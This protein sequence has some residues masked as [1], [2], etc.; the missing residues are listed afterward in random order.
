MADFN[1]STGWTDRC[2]LSVPCENYETFQSELERIRQLKH[3][4]WLQNR[5]TLLC[6]KDASETEEKKHSPECESQN[7]LLQTLSNTNELIENL[8][9]KGI[10]GM[11]EKQTKRNNQLQKIIKE[12]NTV[13]HELKMKIQSFNVSKSAPPPNTES[14]NQNE[15]DDITWTRPKKLIKLTFPPTS[16][17][18]PSKTGLNL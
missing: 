12:K 5:E 15:Q 16:E 17:K 11:L 18:P 6:S 3:N 9:I 7:L 13:I 14:K 2:S 8:D 4:L 1:V 10:I